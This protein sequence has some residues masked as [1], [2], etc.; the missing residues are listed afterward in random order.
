MLSR[1]I[2]DGPSGRRNYEKFEY[3]SFERTA[4]NNWNNS[5]QRLAHLM[6]A[7]VKGIS[8]ANRKSSFKAWVEKTPRNEYH[9]ERIRQWRPKAKAVFMVRDPRQTFCSHRRYQ[10]RKA[11][12]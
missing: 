5:S 1:G 9:L 7:V 12:P 4:I 3:S 6:E 8:I 10:Q 11:N 2:I